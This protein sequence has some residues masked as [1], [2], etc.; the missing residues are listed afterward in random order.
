MQSTT[1]T[2]ANKS[3]WQFKEKTFGQLSLT[4]K[5]QS[6]FAPQHLLNNVPIK[7]MAEESRQRYLTLTDEGLTI[8][9]WKETTF[10]I[11]AIT[12]QVRFVVANLQSQLIGLLDLNDN[13][14]IIHSGDN[15]YIE[16]FGYNEQLHLLGQHL[17][18]AAIALPGPGNPGFHT[19]NEI[20]FENTVQKRYNLI[21]HL[22]DFNTSHWRHRRAQSTNQHSKTTE[23]ASTT[24]KTRT[25]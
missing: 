8:Q 9:G 15:P 21:L 10:I 25:R 2:S 4:L 3:P 5:Q 6:T 14:T 19:P 16:Q 7:P 1:S 20:Q 22:Q 17:H 11:G 13:K 12:M 23:T 18:I 24:N